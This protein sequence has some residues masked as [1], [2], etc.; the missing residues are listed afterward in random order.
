MAANTIRGAFGTILRRVAPPAEY[1]RIFEPRLESGPSGL[2][3][4]PRPF[5][6]R[7]A[8]LDG[9]RFASGEEFSFD[10]L[11]FGNAARHVPLFEAVFRELGAE[12][13]GPRRGAVKLLSVSRLPV[14]T[15]S[16]QADASAP[17][18]VLVRFLTPT[19]I[20]LEGRLIEEP[21]F[22]ALLSRIRDRVSTLRELYG[23]GALPIDFRALAERARVVTTTF[24]NTHR[25]HRERRSTRTG[26]SHPL[27]GFTGEIEYAGD[28]REFLPYLRAAEWT[29]VGRHT[30][31]GNGQI[32]LAGDLTSPGGSPH[33]GTE[34]VS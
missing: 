29:G 7:A 15:L 1:Q 28:L 8:A 31:W 17:A 4:V 24:A 25:Q 20:K 33:T 32:E 27:G 22:F 2:A 23:D 26:Q 16:L 19:E 5:V 34:G 12:G 10:V 6:I 30:V 11:L 3:D 9:A 18:R 14:V 13:L 21:P